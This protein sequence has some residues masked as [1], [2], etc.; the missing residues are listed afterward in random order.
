MA[1]DKSSND[2]RNNDMMRDDEVLSRISCTPAVLVFSEFFS[3]LKQIKTLVKK[4]IYFTTN[5]AF[6]VWSVTTKILNINRMLNGAKM[7][8]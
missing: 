8:S 6:G 5:M 4:E 7:R 2:I 3:P 1:G